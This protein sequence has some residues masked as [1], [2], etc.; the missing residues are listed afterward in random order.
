MLDVSAIMTFSVIKLSHITALER[1]SLNDPAV[2]MDMPLNAMVS[3]WQIVESMVVLEVSA[4]MT[5]SVTKLSHMTA[6]ERVSLN[7]P[8]V[9]M[10]IPLNAMDSP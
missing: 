3:P 1:V 5:F 6:L 7:D 2:E 10:D 9:E 4:I 8:A